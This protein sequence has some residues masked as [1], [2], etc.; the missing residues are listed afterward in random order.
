[1]PESP[2]L[3]QEE[4]NGRLLAALCYIPFFLINI[5]AM[6]YVLV[7]HK[8]GKFARFHAIQSIFLLVAYIVV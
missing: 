8:G 1:M 7:G 2:E 6:L 5:I 4:K 3:S